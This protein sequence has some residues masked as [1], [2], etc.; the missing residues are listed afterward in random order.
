MSQL[1]RIT[2]DIP[3][4]LA[5]RL[6][7]DCYNIKRKKKVRH[8]FDLTNCPMRQIL[9]KYFSVIIHFLCNY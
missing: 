2:L 1:P 3:K 5:T 9:E 8:N 6:E 4:P 7:D